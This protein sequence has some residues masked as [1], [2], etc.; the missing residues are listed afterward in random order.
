MAEVAPG[1]VALGLGA[2]SL[3][4]LTQQGYTVDRPLTRLREYV[5]AV[6]AA[7]NG[8][9]PVSYAGRYVRFDGLR[10]EVRPSSPP[11]IYFCVAGP[12]ALECAAVMADGVVLD[13]FMLPAYVQRTRSRLDGAA[14]GRYGGEVA[15]VLVTSLAASGAEAAARLRPILATYLVQFPELARE[16]GLDPELVERLR[17]QARA[18]GLEATYAALPDDLVARYA[19]CGPPAACRERVAEYRAAGLQLPILFP[20]PDS[21]RDVVTAL[22][23]A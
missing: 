7:W 4:P 6:R 17:A 5:E 18:G 9:A 10:P 19:L 23:G 8:P 22:A 20:E 12:R 3:P 11:P 21:L 13:A 14:G 16:T 2:G 1:R 15:G